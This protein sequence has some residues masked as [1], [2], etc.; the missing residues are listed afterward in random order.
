MQCNIDIFSKLYL[1]PKV[2]KPMIKK[3]LPIV[4]I[5]LLITACASQ[6]E[7]L[8][9]PSLAQYVID[10]T[11][12]Q[13]DEFK[14]QINY[15]GPNIGF[16]PDQVFIRAWK[17]EKDNTISYQI[18]VSDNYDT[19]WRFYNSAYDS[20]GN[21]LDMTLISKNVIGCTRYSG[22]S[23]NETFGINI[24][25]EYLVKHRDSGIRFQ[26][27]GNSVNEIFS[28]P[29]EYIKGFLKALNDEPETPAPDQKTKN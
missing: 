17:H 27:S 14:K 25:R 4:A 28:V 16:A 3:S 21:Q 8:K 7:S 26:A 2:Q 23:Y 20:D 18:F 1:Q 10:S 5:S 29:A 15:R 6:P 12:V 19:N 22:C 9:P 24:S 11:S 13:R